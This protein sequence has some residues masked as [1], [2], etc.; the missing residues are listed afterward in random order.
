MTI[1]DSA[2]LLVPTDTIIIALVRLASV[3]LQFDNSLELQCTSIVTLGWIDAGMDA[4]PLVR[5]CRL[6]VY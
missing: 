2:V 6:R 5:S 4:T 3:V 1:D